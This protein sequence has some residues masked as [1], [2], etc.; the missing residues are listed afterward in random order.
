MKLV[1]RIVNSSINIKK[2]IAYALNPV[3]WCEEVI[4][5]KPDPWQAAMLMSNKRR[6]LL[7]CSRQA[8]KSTVVSLRALWHALYHPCSLI[9]IA[10]PTERQSK[11][12]FMKIKD[13]YR[14]IPN[15]P[16]LPEDNKLSMTLDNGSWIQAIP[17]NN[18]G[19]VRGY[20]APALVIEDESAQCSDE[21]FTALLPMV[22]TNDGQVILLSSPFGKRGHFYNSY[23][24]PE[25][26]WE[27]I[28]ITAHDCPRISPEF[29]EEQRKLMTEMEWRSEFF[30]SFEDTIN[31]VFSS[32]LLYSACDDDLPPLLPGKAQSPRWKDDEPVKPWIEG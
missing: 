22:S 9:L 20:S 16:K 1:N 31:S 17:G 28:K 27:R 26:E 10:S 30:C 32:D 29:L 2:D 7:L 6:F 24:N 12:L 11:I 3:L 15:Q 23:S 25:I 5:F 8:G 19:N 14:L 4:R 13:F 21:L 18:P